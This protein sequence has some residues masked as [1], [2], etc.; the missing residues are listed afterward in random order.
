MLENRVLGYSAVIATSKLKNRP[1][2][3]IEAFGLA[4]SDRRSPDLGEIDR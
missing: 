1:P 3:Q 4:I 2:L